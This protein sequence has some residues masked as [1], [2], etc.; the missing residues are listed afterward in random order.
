M[1]ICARNPLTAYKSRGIWKLQKKW[2]DFICMRDCIRRNLYRQSAVSPF[3][4][5]NI[6]FLLYL[7]SSQ[8]CRWWSES[9]ETWCQE[10]VLPPFAR[11]SFL[12][13]YPEDGDDEFSETSA[14][15]KETNEDEI[16]Y[17]RFH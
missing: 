13:G 16:I 10:T 4:G 2:E 8:I 5:P 17:C 11:Y 9:P 15:Y 14:N 6:S 12:L 7:R 1:K 3:Y